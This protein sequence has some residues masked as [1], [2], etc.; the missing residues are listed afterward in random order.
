MFIIKWKI[1]EV[2]NCFYQ[3]ICVYYQFTFTNTV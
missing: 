2:Q 3:Y 1:M